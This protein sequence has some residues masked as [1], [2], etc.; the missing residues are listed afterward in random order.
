MKHEHFTDGRIDDICSGR[1]S[2]TAE[3]R[4][5]LL[6]DTPGFEECT[7]T[8]AELAAMSDADLMSAAYSVW[9]DYARCMY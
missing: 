2:L 7:Y 1:T 3:E 5:F 4:A 9:A 6:A 8:E